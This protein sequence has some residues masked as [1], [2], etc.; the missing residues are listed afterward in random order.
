M[1]HM[2]VIELRCLVIKKRICVIKF[3]MII[4]RYTCIYMVLYKY[5][6]TWKKNVLECRNLA[7]FPGLSALPRKAWERG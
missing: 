7:S 6:N 5:C 4:I 3:I 2:F 1:H